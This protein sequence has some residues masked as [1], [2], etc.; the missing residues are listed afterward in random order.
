MMCIERLKSLTIP[1][2]PID[3]NR[4][5][6]TIMGVSF[7]SVDNFEAAV[8]TLGTVMFEGF[9]PSPKSIE[10][11][12]DYMLDYCFDAEMLSIYKSVCRHLFYKHPELVYNAVMNYKEVWDSDDEGVEVEDGDE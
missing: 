10:H 8:N 5:N 7:S 6:L 4:K 11:I 3:V 9:A 1:Y 12:L 2:K